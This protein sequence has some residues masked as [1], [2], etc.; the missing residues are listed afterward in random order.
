MFNI[1]K[2]LL[3]KQGSRN[4]F[5]NDNQNKLIEIRNKK[6]AKELQRIELEI[7]CNVIPSIPS[8]IIYDSSIIWKLSK[9]VYMQHPAYGHNYSVVM[10]DSKKFYRLWLKSYDSVFLCP[11]KKDMCYSIKYHDAVIGFSQ[12]IKNPVPLA[13]VSLWK[14]DTIHFWS[15]F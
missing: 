3:K 13:I 6:I 10:V 7:A 1:I 2:N 5:I 15:L 14:D 11:H 9:K 4:L 8:S 12:G